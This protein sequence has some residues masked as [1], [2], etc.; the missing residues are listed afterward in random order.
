MT[1]FD[2]CV[3]LNPH[4]IEAALFA[5]RSPLSKRVLAP[6][7]PSRSRPTA[8]SSRR[9]TSPTGCVR[10]F[11]PSPY[12]LVVIDEAHKLRNADRP[13]STTRLVS[14]KARAATGGVFEPPLQ[15]R[16]RRQWAD[17]VAERLLGLVVLGLQRALEVS[18]KRKGHAAFRHMSFCCKD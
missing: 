8:W 12:D 16:H 1:L 6:A 15:E 2:A 13:S 5:L 17:Y 9:S 4:P 11:A 14:R 18:E 10:R 3:D 7:T